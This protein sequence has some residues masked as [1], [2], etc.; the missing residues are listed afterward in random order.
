[1]DSIE[2]EKLKCE[3]GAYK[4]LKDEIKDKI[5]QFQKDVISK[6]IFHW[7]TEALIDQLYSELRNTIEYEK[8][9][10]LSN[11]ANADSIFEKYFRSAFLEVFFGIIINP[12]SL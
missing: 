2:F 5:S 4:A 12:K 9:S 3:I 6:H 8:F 7:Q 1:M 11:K 10:V